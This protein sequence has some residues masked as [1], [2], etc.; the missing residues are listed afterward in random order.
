MVD[1]TEG[2]QV[3]QL[4]AS[5]VEPL[6]NVVDLEPAAPITWTGSTYDAAVPIALEDCG[7]D[8]GLHLA[9][10]RGEKVERLEN[11]F[12]GAQIWAGVPRR[13][14]HATL[15]SEL[16][17]ATRNLLYARD[18]VKLLKL[19]YPPNIRSEVRSDAIPGIPRL[20][21]NIVRNSPSFSLDR[22]RF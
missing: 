6:H 21:S 13:D 7:P 18:V 15:V 2:P 3:L 4:V 11:V 14:A 19:H 12:V 5:S 8:G 1:V 10:V 20:T 9:L 16:T 17:D 22:I